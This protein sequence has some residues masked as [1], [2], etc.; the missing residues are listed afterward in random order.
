M[1]VTN[2]YVLAVL[3]S[4]S[5]FNELNLFTITIPQSDAT[6]LTFVII[7]NATQLNMSWIISGDKELTK[8]VQN[9]RKLY[10][11]FLD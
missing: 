10:A 8:M 2:D 4:L 1:K 9:R 11:L 6:T 5:F 7:T 3:R